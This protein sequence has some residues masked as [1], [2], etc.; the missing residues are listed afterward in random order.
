MVPTMTERVCILLATSSSYQVNV[1]HGAAR[2]AREFMMNTSTT[3]PST[4]QKPQATA[5]APAQAGQ[6]CC[7]T[8]KQSTCCDAEAKPDCCG[9]A[10][11]PGPKCGC[12]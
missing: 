11:K 3:V 7:D 8:Q 10:P 1:R 4:P 6:S 12:Q 2:K 5:P 9:P